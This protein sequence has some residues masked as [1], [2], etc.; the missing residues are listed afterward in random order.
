MCES[1]QKTAVRKIVIRTVWDG[2]I[3]GAVPGLPTILIDR[4][5]KACIMCFI[6][7]ERKTKKTKWGEVT[8]SLHGKEMANAQW[9]P[10]QVKVSVPSKRAEKTAGCP[11]CTLKDLS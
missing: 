1:F 6:M 2:E 8:C 3:P 10:K 9:K 5:T 4:N 11:K 7:A